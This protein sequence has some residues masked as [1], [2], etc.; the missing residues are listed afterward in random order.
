MLLPK[1]PGK[2]PAVKAEV[3]VSVSQ[4]A[5]RQTGL[6]GYLFFFFSPLTGFTDLTLDDDGM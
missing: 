6:F 3:D 4:Y 5:G 1:L 2:P